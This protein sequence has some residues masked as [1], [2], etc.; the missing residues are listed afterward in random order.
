MD[1]AYN[2]HSSAAKRKNRSSTNLNHLTLAPL[3]SKLPLGDDDDLVDLVSA[4]ANGPLRIPS[5]SYLQ[6]KS[7]PTTPRL[8]S[9]S[10]GGSAASGRRSQS[11]PRLPKSKSATHIAPLSSFSTNSAS[12]G[13][14]PPLSAS[15]TASPTASR[16]KGGVSGSHHPHFAPTIHD[17]AG[18]DW[19]LRAGALISTETRESKGQAWL[20]SRASST[21]LAGMRDADD[22][23]DID[24][25]YVE[26]EQQLLAAAAASRNASRRGSL[27]HVAT[28]GIVV[29]DDHVS[30]YSPTHSRYGSRSHS[31]VGSR[32]QM[33]VTPRDHRSM[34]GY[35]S[36]TPG[37]V[38]ASAS[39]SAYGGDV[40]DDSTAV[41]GPD[42]VNLDEKLEAI[43]QH[44]SVDDEAY[45]RRLVKHG[46][47]GVGTWFGSVLGVNL[48]SVN[49]DEE[50]S[51][52]DEEESASTDG[53]LDVD[54]DSGEGDQATQQQRRASSSSRRLEGFTTALE[55]R[56]PSPKADE[57]GWQDAAWLLTVASKVLL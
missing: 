13:G 19:L 10:P 40:D 46:N 25:G 55:E 1:V 5:T 42:F 52:D 2:Q 41:A 53:E 28:A 27:G 16:R 6:G 18:S 21:S 43:E 47:G 39:A 50:E 20:V 30:V 36:L 15:A 33:L 24:G 23:E 51:D 8:L 14:K 12:H 31:R 22:Y 17:D 11:R 34:D 45:V 38:A 56:M 54:D 3:T 7:A 29:E 4:A 32:T 35:F 57:G 37:S 44:T 9:R 26:R 49:E 48:F